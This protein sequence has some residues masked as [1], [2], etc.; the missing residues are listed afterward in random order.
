MLL[1]A[2]WAMFVPGPKG[3]L[4]SVVPDASER[5][6]EP[7]TFELRVA[8]APRAASLI[9]KA[10]RISSDLTFDYVPLGTSGQDC[11]AEHRADDLNG[12]LRFRELRTLLARVPLRLECDRPCES[13]TGVAL[14][15]SLDGAVHVLQ[16]NDMCWH[17]HPDLQPLRTAVEGIVAAAYG[18]VVCG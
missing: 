1:F 10:L 2:G 14:E 5:L 9:W 3:P 17:T 8:E 11:V 7:F 15:W 6:V 18:R 12:V 4:R 13:C 16:L